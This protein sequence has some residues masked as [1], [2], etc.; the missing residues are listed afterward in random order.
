MIEGDWADIEHRIK[1]IDPNLKLVLDYKKERYQIYRN[2]HLI[3]EILPKE[4][5][6]RVLLKLREIDLQNKSIK[7]YLKE[8]DEQN[9]RIK[10]YADQ[11]ETDQLDDILDYNYKR[12][13]NE[14][15]VNVGN[16]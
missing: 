4:L 5:D 14:K 8:I 9:E 13:M 15:I 1:E 2:R 7:D 10:R 16:I 12:I 11:K 3:I 6:G